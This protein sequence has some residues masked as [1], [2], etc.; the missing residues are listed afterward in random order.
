M[1]S[2]FSGYR[3]LLAWSWWESDRPPISINFVILPLYY[4][5]ITLPRHR[6]PILNL[7]L[8][9]NRKHSQQISG[10]SNPITS[11]PFAPSHPLPSGLWVLWYIFLLMKATAISPHQAFEPLLIPQIQVPLALH[12]IKITPPPRAIT[13]QI[14][15]FLENLRDG[16]DDS[17]FWLR[18]I[19]FPTPLPRHLCDCACAARCRWSSLHFGPMAFF[20]LPN[21]LGRNFPFPLHIRMTS[22]SM[23]TLMKPCP[24]SGRKS[25]RRIARTASRASRLTDAQRG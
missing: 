2:P 5:P 14:T 25:L 3:A 20:N 11:C 7:S 10:D 6:I 17:V 12:A 22:F 15:D 8:P 1:P 9:T 21:V 19:I 16:S 4:P 18:R 24:P 23:F 13:C